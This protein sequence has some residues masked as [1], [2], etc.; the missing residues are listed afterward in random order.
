MRAAHIKI[1]VTSVTATLGHSAANSGDVSWFGRSV[2]RAVT[3]RGEVTDETAHRV[4]AGLRVDGD[5]L[6]AREIEVLK[7]SRHETH[8]R[9]ALVEGKNRELR[10]LFAACGY[11]VT[12]LK[13][14]AF[15][16]LELGTLAPG[17]WRVLEPAELRR[18]FPRAP[19]RIL[20]S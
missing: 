8:L 16:E 9:V 19:L 3:L 17:K 11:E 20:D 6:R 4:R 1:S 18:A 15:S 12:R 7:R 10:R 5:L 2:G 14:V 13:R